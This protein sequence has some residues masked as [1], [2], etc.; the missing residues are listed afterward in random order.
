[1]IGV[2]SCLKCQGQRTS[3]SPTLYSHPPEALAYT[4]TVAPPPRFEIDLVKDEV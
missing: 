2:Q 4:D 1:M 3:D